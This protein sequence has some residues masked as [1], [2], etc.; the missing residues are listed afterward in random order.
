MSYNDIICLDVGGTRFATTRQTLCSDPDSML[1]RMFNP[2]SNLAPSQVQDG[3]YFIDRDPDMFKILLNF[4]RTG[5][6][7]EDLSRGQLKRLATEA[8]F[9]QLTKLTNAIKYLPNNVL[10]F[11]ILDLSG[12]NG[13]NSSEYQP[14]NLIVAKRSWFEN[15]PVHVIVKLL[16]SPPIFYQ[17]QDIIIRLAE[18][19]QMNDYVVDRD[20]NIYIYA[21]SPDSVIQDIS[22]LARGYRGGSIAYL[23]DHYDTDKRG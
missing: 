18:S 7:P 10:Q 8:D 5:Q 3:A 17:P 16:E 2:E 21:V 12:K 1:A 11:R 13:L 22:S 23:R 14:E 6:L 4:L 15:I 9:F 20:G 19:C